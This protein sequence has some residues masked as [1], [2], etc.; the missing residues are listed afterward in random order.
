MPASYDLP[1]K[2]YLILTIWNLISE[3]LVL[4]IFLGSWNIVF[5]HLLTLEIHSLTV[6]IL[7]NAI[8]PINLDSRNHGIS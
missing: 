7:S 1:I 8:F 4:L 2:Q 3:E 6:Y 5:S